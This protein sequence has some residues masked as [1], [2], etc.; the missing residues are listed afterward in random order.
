MRSLF[1]FPTIAR[2]IALYLWQTVDEFP[3]ADEEVF[4]PPAYREAL[5][6]RHIGYFC[7][8]CCPACRERLAV[9]EVKQLPNI[10]SGFTRFDCPF[11]GSMML[12]LPALLAVS[13]DAGRYP[14]T[15]YSSPRL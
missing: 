11:H 13:S 15:P 12:G 2:Q 1:S 5:K 9:K 4:V 3:N 6:Y 8:K 7:E 14:T 10:G